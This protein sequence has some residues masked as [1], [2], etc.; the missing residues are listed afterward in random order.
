MSFVFA[1]LLMFLHG[2][3]LAATL[4]WH[5]AQGVKEK[6]WVYFYMKDATQM[7]TGVTQEQLSSRIV[8]F[9]DEL[10]KGGVA[11]TYYSKDDALANLQRRLP[12]M[13][14]NFDQYGIENPLPVTLYVTFQDQQQYDFVME[15]KKWYEDMLLAGPSGGNTEQQF[16]RN[17]RV[18]NVLHVLQFFFVFII[19]AC[20][21]VI[22]VFLSMIIKTKF[23]AMQHTINVQKLLGSPFNRLK[24]PFFF[25][26][27]VLLVLWY[28]MTLILSAILI[29]NLSSIFPY[30]F[31]MSLSDLFGGK[32]GL[33]FIRLFVEFIAMLGVAR[34]Y[35]NWQLTQLLRKE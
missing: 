17:A 23:T 21:V 16:T 12:N 27:F 33:R 2:F 28:I 5:A 13:V 25:N 14:K 24:K 19:I 29:Y 11:V 22:L 6:L 30:L 32:I 10:E 1:L 35:A 15:A 7:W 20:V 3:I 9:K 34:V 8:K 26:S 18:I 31:G 4:T